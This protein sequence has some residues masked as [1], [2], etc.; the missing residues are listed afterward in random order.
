MSK[1][2]TI[3]ACGA[4]SLTEQ[5]PFGRKMNQRPSTTRPLRI[6]VLVYN[7]R[8]AG[9]LS[10][11]RNILAAIGRQAPQ[12]EYIVFISP[13]IGFEEIC[14][15]IP[16]CH[17]IICPPFRRR[18]EKMAFEMFRLPKMIR[19]SC[20]DVLLAAGNRGLMKP[21]CPQAI[22][23]RD[24]HYCYP[25]RSYVRGTWLTTETLSCWLYVRVQNWLIRRQLRRSS[26]LLSQTPI[27]E[28][29]L[30]E[31]FRF[32]GTTAV[33]PNA[34]STFLI[35][36]GA[37]Q[38]VPAPLVP[39]ANK[40][41]LLYVAGYYPHKNLE[42]IV[43]AF[44]R[45]RDELRGVVV[46]LT[47]SPERPVVRKFLRTIE[48]RGL[49]DRIINVGTIPQSALAQYY[50]NCQG[51]LMPTLLESFSSAYLEAMHFGTPIL[52][53]DLDFA[54]GICGDAAIYFD[55]WSPE[56]MKDAI[57]QLKNTLNLAQ[58][59]TT[60]GRVRLQSMSRSWDEVAVGV[61]KLLEEIAERER[62]LTENGEL[63]G[64]A[65]KDQT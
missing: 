32:G 54:H 33:F 56:A 63:D 3:R 15:G 65:N 30:R 48:R 46:V 36:G 10:V 37:D 18:I 4:T 39:H 29:R 40:M 17:T 2:P 58:E 1:T 22:Y 26:L 11:A 59:L 6:A 49:G 35:D 60:M 55:P 5:D 16:H 28:R 44:G 23:I 64:Q 38:A 14:S 12:H 31:M 61:V 53:S 8:T 43:E 24:A 41:R 50:Q 52:T 42:G 45:Y 57:L 51:L 47:L 20:P 19:D 34:V 7:C 27:M 25:M 62:V 9:G 21:P 13:G